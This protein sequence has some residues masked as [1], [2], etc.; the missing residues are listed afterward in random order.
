MI[1]MIPVQIGIDAEYGLPLTIDL[2]HTGHFCVVGGTGSGKSVFTLYALYKLLRSGIPVDL[3]V[4]DFK[5]SG[6]YAHISPHFAEG[7]AVTCLVED[8]Y[9]LFETV[10]EGGNNV[11]HILLLDEYAGFCTWLTQHDKKKAEE[12]KGK[13]ANIL[14]LGRSRRC[15]VWCIQQRITATL[16]PAGIGAID[17]FQVCVGLGRLSPDSRRSLFAGEYPDD[18]AFMQT[19][20][21]GTGKGLA[22]VDGQGIR[23]FVVP[24]IDSEE[25]LRALCHKYA[26]LK[27]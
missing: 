1:L 2:G 16:F 8:Y 15:Y 26:I 22:M 12:I 9:A 19:F 3:H 27:S 24:H 25:D 13:I 21:P 4:G 20:M 11:F 18:T 5:K 10:P 6:D 14:M 7:D 23:P 17:N